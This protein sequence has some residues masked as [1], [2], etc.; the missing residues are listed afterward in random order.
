M[1]LVNNWDTKLVGPEAINEELQARAEALHVEETIKAYKR[2][3][4]TE[5][6]KLILADLKDSLNDGT[7]FVPGEPHGTSFN[8][9]ARSVYLG[10]LDMLLRVIEDPPIPIEGEVQ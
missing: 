1:T 3:F 10:I 7:S 2:L 9:G 5:D 4:T 6:G 8:E